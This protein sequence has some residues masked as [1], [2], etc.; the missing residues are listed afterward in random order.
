MNFIQLDKRCKSDPFKTKQNKEAARYTDL[1]SKA[2]TSFAEQAFSWSAAG[3]HH[4]HRSMISHQRI[5]EPSL[6]K[7]N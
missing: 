2:Q 6:E 1:L 3:P 4:Q 5:I 7:N